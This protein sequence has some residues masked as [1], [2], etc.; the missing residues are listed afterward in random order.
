[1]CS[2]DL[3]YLNQNGYQVKWDNVA[4]APYIVDKNGNFYLSFDNALSIYFK[5]EY[6]YENCLGGIFGW[7][8]GM[9]SANILIN[10]MYLAMNNPEEL[11]E[12]LSKSYYG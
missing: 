8:A 7:Q 9:D 4:K 11:K 12:V 2:S 5:G 1:M 10:A 3:S 6:V